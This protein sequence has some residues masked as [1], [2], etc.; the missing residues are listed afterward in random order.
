MFKVL[1]LHDETDPLRVLKAQSKR[2]QKRLQQREQARG[3]T[4]LQHNVHGSNEDEWTSQVPRAES[5]ENAAARLF[6]ELLGDGSNGELDPALLEDIAQQVQQMSLQQHTNQ[7]QRPTQNHQGA[8][9]ARSPA[10]APRA[11]GGYGST[12]LCLT[13]SP[14]GPGLGPG[15]GFNQQ[16]QQQR[17]NSGYHQQ[18]RPG[19]QQWPSIVRGASPPPR[20]PTTTADLEY[21]LMQLFTVSG[22]IGAGG[23]GSG[24]AGGGG[25]SPSVSRPSTASSSHDWGSQSGSVPAEEFPSLARAATTERPATAAAAAAAGSTK[26]KARAGSH[27]VGLPVGRHGP[28]G[29]TATG[30][31]VL[32]AARPHAGG[33]AGQH[34]HQAAAGGGADFNLRL[35]WELLGSGWCLLEDPLA[36]GG[37]AGAAAAGGGAGAA[38]AGGGLGA[39]GAAGPDAAANAAIRRLVAAQLAEQDDGPARVISQEDMIAMMTRAH[40]RQYTGAGTRRARQRRGRRGGGAAGGSGDGGCGSGSSSDSDSESGSSED[41]AHYYNS[42]DDSK[43]WRRTV[44]MMERSDWVRVTDTDGKHFKYRRL[45]PN[46]AIQT[47]TVCCSPSDAVRGVRNLQADLARKDTEAN[48]VIKA[49]RQEQRLAKKAAAAAAAAAAAEDS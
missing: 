31:K 43:S 4:L 45:L 13:S 41:E 8:A 36:E 39:L 18:H 20:P 7:L 19:A 37:A 10:S 21:S 24:A 1:A 17:S 34:G 27:R 22:S 12:A 25:G 29:T 28:H 5:T 49:W 26:R 35:L 16:L 15:P 9:G 48:A 44:D 40:R 46:G 14:G 32:H 2:A 42:R 47:Q 30:V 38:A 23:G 3:G 6:D 11:G 33:G